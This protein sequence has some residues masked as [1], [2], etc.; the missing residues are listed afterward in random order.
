MRPKACQPDPKLTGSK[1][2]MELWKSPNHTTKSWSNTASPDP[3][4][5]PFTYQHSDD[6]TTRTTYATKKKQKQKQKQKQKKQ[7]QNQTQKQNKK[8]KSLQSE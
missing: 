2:T 1:P 6:L 8:T 4:L 3:T 5:A 7:N